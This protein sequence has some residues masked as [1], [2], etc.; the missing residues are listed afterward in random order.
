MSKNF[1]LFIFGI[2]VASTPFIGLPVQYRTY[3]LLIIG[4]LIALLSLWGEKGDALQA[5]F[6]TPDTRTQNLFD[7]EHNT[8][9]GA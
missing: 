5:Y 6:K 8:E 3:G 7:T 4:L 1:L 2:F 9:V